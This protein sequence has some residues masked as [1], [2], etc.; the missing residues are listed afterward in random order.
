MVEWYINNTGYAC[1]VVSFISATCGAGNVYKDLGSRRDSGVVQRRAFGAPAVGVA[2]RRTTSEAA[3]HM[4]MFQIVLK[5]TTGL[6]F[7]RFIHESAR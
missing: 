6:Q 1:D 3:R 4:C 5:Q 7:R 2:E